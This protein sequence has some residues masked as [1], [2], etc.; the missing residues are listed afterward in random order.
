MSDDGQG[1]ELKMD[2]SMELT[3]DQFN[4]LTDD[5][6]QQVKDKTGE[7]LQNASLG[8]AEVS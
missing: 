8:S 6:K 7:D 1:L 2:G 5:Q 4:G 3:Q